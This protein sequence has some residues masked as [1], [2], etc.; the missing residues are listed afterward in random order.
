ML[1]RGKWNGQTILS[2]S[3][4]DLATAKQVANDVYAPA[5]NPDW[6]AGY[7]FQFWR[8]QRQGFRGDGAFGQAS[9]VLPESDVV[10]A[11]TAGMPDLQPFLDLVWTHLI[12]ALGERA[13]EPRESETKALTVQLNSLSCPLPSGSLTS[14]RESELARKRVVCES[15]L[16]GWKSL[17]WDSSGSEGVLVVET[18]AGQQRLHAGRKVWREDSTPLFAGLGGLWPVAGSYSERMMAGFAWTGP[19]TL[20]LIVRAVETPFRY[21][22]SLHWEDGGFRMEGQSNVA[23]FP[24]QWPRLVGVIRPRS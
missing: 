13:V 5:G 18:A 12:P 22:L 2:E 1:Q 19:D 16:L 6:R 14:P 11:V 9:I 17:Q 3:W 21:T 24:T 20:T 4:V 8:N 23:F 15:H 10:V 7:G